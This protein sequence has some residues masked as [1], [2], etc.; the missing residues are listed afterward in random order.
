MCDILLAKNIGMV[1]LQTGAPSAALWSQLIFI[2]GIVVLMYFFLI[3]P[4]QRQQKKE[5]KFRESLK[6][7][8]KVITTAGI[9]GE[10][11]HVEDQSVLLEVDK[12]VKLRVEKMAIRSYAPGYDGGK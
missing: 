7:G 3:L 12:N 5:R 11:L 4:Q 1:Y 10:I 8:D 2:L 6:K 9:Y